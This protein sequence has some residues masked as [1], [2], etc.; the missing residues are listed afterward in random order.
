[1]RE[2]IT[3]WIDQHDNADNPLIPAATVLLLRDS[4][5]GPETVLM[6]R[7]SKLS[8][9]Q[10]AWVFPGGRIDPDDYPAPDDHMGAAIRAAVREAREEAGLHLAADTLEYYSHWIPPAQTPKRFSTWFFVARAPEGDVVVDQGEILDH[11]WCR[12]SQALALADRR[13]IELLPPTWMTLH[14]LVQFTTVEELLT[15]VRSRGPLAYATKIVQTVDGPAALWHGDAAFDD[16]TEPEAPGPRHRLVLIDGR[17][18][19]EQTPSHH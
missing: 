5:D 9:A 6:R 17:W 3:R 10:G 15:K 18:H 14:D 7:S 12:P 2:R 19:L 11:T 4:P 13:E 8:F 1:M 16:D